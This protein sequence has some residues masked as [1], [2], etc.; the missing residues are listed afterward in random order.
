MTA[1]LAVAPSPVNCGGCSAT[2]D[3]CYVLRDDCCQNCTHYPESDALGPDVDPIA[4]E[5]AIAGDLSV[6]LNRDE[7]AEAHRQL[8]A[9]GKSAAQIAALLGTTQ[10]NV[11]RWTNGHSRPISRRPGGA[12]NITSNESA[13]DALLR[14]AAQS[15]STRIRRA[16]ERVTEAL[17]RLR[18]EF[19]A[20]EG[21]REAR[22]RVERLERELREAKAALRGGAASTPKQRKTPEWSGELLACRNG[23]GKTSPNPQGRAAHERFCTVEKAS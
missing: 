3:E 17:D 21:K 15:E 22:E 12:M 9:Q 13:T 10:R 23:C 1:D 19:A 2:A 5:R 14:R 20:D 7:Y 18:E 4:V 16:A 11:V 6:S 8:H